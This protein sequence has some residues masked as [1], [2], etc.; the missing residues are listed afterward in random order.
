MD[1]KKTWE[2]VNEIIEVLDAA[3][4]YLDF[5]EQKNPSK[6]MIRVPQE[7]E[8][9]NFLAETSQMTSLSPKPLFLSKQLGVPKDPLSSEVNPSGNPMSPTALPKNSVSLIQEGEEDEEDEESKQG[10][11]HG[12]EGE[13]EV[14][15]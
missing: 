9:R 10:E 1:K 2:Q 5:P 3:C 6:F 13:E 12:R 7:P 4:K 11:E 8:K 15:G 14:D